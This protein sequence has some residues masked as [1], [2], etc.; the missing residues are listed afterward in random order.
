MAEVKDYSAEALMAKEHEVELDTD[1]VK[2]ENVQVE[3][4]STKEETPNL[5]V[6]EVDLGYTGHDKPEE[7]KTEKPEIEV[8]EDKTETPVEEKVE[9]ETEKEKPNLNESRRDYQKRIDKLVFQK[10]EAERREKAALDFAKGIQKKFDSNLQKL[11]STDDQY[12]KELDARVDAQREQ[13]K[14]ALQSAIESQDASKIMEANDKLTQLAVE[15]EKAR[16]EMNNREQM[17]K[18]E[19]EKSKQ[20]QNVQAEPQTAE[21]S[22]TVPQITPRAKKW[23]EENTWFGN[24]EVMTNAAI[25]IHNNISQEGIEVDSDEYY[26][27]VNSRLKGYFPESFGDTNDEQKKETPKPVQTVASA[28]RSQQGRRTVKLTKSQVAIAKR[29]GVPLEEYARYVKEDK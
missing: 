25:T 29:L 3:E 10:K 12:L 4:K 19:E 23:A 21:T 24:D 15:K 18:A 14:V 27:E 28:G 22:Q 11:N 13:V 5:N 8:T 6:G 9:S 7:D 16:L 1:N 20:Q 26:N 2:E 17:K